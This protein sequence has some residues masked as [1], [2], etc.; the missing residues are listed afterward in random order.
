M[1]I[2]RATSNYERWLT[3]TQR[4][5]PADIRRKHRLM[6][7]SLFG[8]FRGSFFRWSQLWQSWCPELTTAPRVPAVGDLHVENFGTWRD[9]EGRLV[10]GINDFDEAWRLPY[11]NDLVRLTTSALLAVKDN[12]LSLGDAA[13]TQ[14][15][16]EGYQAGLEAAGRPLV[17]AEH[18]EALRS[19]ADARLREAKGYWA[20]LESLPAVSGGSKMVFRWLRQALPPGS[21]V[22]RWVHRTSGLG[23]MGRERVAVLADCCGSK[24]AREAKALAPSACA[25][26]EG[27]LR[28]TRHWPSFLVKNAVRCPDPSVQIRRGWCIR[29]LA[30][31]CSRIDLRM[32]GSAG[33]E[34]RVLQSMGWE[35]ANVH[36]ASD[37]RASILKDLAGRQE[38]WLLRASRRATTAIEQDYRLWRGA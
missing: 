14:T 34:R 9:Y 8:F 28:P 13:I 17:L 10:W 24:V 1:H 30:P 4:L 35:T 22:N 19:L 18:N 27:R 37:A 16:L 33:D 26:A 2:R 25:W 7:E 29:R 20:K 6:R 12:A 38:K 3:I 32:L 36:L 23:S 11:T 15:I 31:D 21:K 5:V